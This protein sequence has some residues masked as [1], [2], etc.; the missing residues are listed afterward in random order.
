M[1]LR[2]Y[3]CGKE[4]LERFSPSFV[5]IFGDV[6]WVGLPSLTLLDAYR[7]IHDI[8]ANGSDVDLVLYE[9]FSVLSCLPTLAS[10]SFIYGISSELIIYIIIIIH[11]LKYIIYIIFLYIIIIIVTLLLYIMFHCFSSDGVEWKHS[12][13]LSQQRCTEATSV[14][15][16]PWHVQFVVY[17]ST[18][19]YASSDCISRLTVFPVR[20]PCIF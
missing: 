6:W 8:G 7:D 18:V 1:K 9:H 2:R 10:V 5:K 12:I 19:F 20:D 17:N 16:S 15:N 3:N 14:V 4:K 11:T 13:K